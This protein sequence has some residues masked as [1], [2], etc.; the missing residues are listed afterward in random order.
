MVDTVNIDAT[1]LECFPQILEEGYVENYDF[2]R[3]WS[4]LHPSAP[5]EERD[6]AVALVASQGNISG[7]ARLLGRARRSIEQFI[8]RNSSFRILQE[9]L[10]E[11]FLD[12]V[13]D[14]Y[15]NDALRG[16]G[17]AKRFFL[18]TIGKKRGYS[19]RTETTGA[20][21]G[22]LQFEEVNRDADAFA[23][24]MARLATGRDSSDGVIEIN[25]RAEGRPELEVA[26]VVG[27]S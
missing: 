17:Q 2:K 11:E 20:D 27:T 25:R 24:R 19:T 3:C 16:D 23:S 26:R 9:D 21:G 14:S 10:V 1:I 13:E 7:V 8:L 15:K 22:P 12:A 5:L 6:L 4:R 18:Q